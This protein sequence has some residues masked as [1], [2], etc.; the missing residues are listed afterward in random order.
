MAKPGRYE[1]GN[2]QVCGFRLE[3]NGR[4]TGFVLYFGTGTAPPV[5]MLFQSLFEISCPA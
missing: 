1:V 4:R 3:K 2:G 5:R